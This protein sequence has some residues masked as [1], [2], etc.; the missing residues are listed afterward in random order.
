VPACA[1]CSLLFHAR[2]AISLLIT[3]LIVLLVAWI[4][5][6]KLDALG[7]SSTSKKLTLLAVGVIALVP[8]MFFEEAFPG[9]FSVTASNDSIVYS[10][11]NREAGIQFRI[12]NE[13]A[14]RL[15]IT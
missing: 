8:Q 12:L 15:G 11:R 7:F 4:L 6:P 10:F 5:S 2:R 3:I 13:G 1:S 9:P 14:K